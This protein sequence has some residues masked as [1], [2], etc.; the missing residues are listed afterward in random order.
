MPPTTGKLPRTFTRFTFFYFLPYLNKVQGAPTPV[1]RTV[2]KTGWRAWIMWNVDD[3]WVFKRTREQ[4]S[5]PKSTS[6]KASYW[7]HFG[8]RS[9][10]LYTHQT[11]SKMPVSGFF[12]MKYL[13]HRSQIISK[14]PISHI[15]SIQL[16]SK[17][18]LHHGMDAEWSCSYLHMESEAIWKPKI[19]SCNHN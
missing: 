8:Y 5:K 10:E 11:P 12:E 7:W 1:F 3:L 19:I 2:A 14:Q 13:L 6:L 9:Q 18:I 16:D 15:Y 17:T 4:Y